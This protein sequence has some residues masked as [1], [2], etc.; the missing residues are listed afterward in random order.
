MS[1]QKER[2]ALFLIRGHGPHRQVLLPLS[3]DEGHSPFDTISTSLPSGKDA[4]STVTE[5]ALRR[6]DLELDLRE[7]AP[8]VHDD[9]DTRYYIIVAEVDNDMVVTIE[10]VP[11]LPGSWV[12]VSSVLRKES[13]NFLDRALRAVSEQLLA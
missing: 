11:A 3:T 9:R 8:V 13:V 10:S 7:L 1:Q 5:F 6:F 2:V 12:P 4:V